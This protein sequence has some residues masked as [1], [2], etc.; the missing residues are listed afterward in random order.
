VEDFGGVTQVQQMV[1]KT[2]LCCINCILGYKWKKPY[3]KK[4]ENAAR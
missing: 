2:E 1:K 3:I 4:K